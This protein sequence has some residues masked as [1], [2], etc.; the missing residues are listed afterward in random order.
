MCSREKDDAFEGAH[1]HFLFLFLFRSLLNDAPE[2]DDI[3]EALSQAEVVGGV[4]LQAE[5]VPVGAGL[6]GGHHSAGL[7][8]GDICHV[9]AKLK[10]SSL[11]HLHRLVLEAGADE[12]DARRTGRGKG[13]GAAHPGGS[14]KGK[15]GGGKEH[16]NLHYI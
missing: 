9:V 4:T 5:D 6:L 16:Y 15:R 13:R 11:P 14:F 7:L 1:S 3:V 8:N 12:G 10:H 2:A